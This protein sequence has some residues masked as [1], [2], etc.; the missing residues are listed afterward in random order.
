MAG[1]R[2]AAG[3][4]IA[5]VGLVLAACASSVQIPEPSPGPQ[6][7]HTCRDLHR[8]LPDRLDD[9]RRRPTEPQSQLLAAWGSPPVAL[10]CGVAE[11]SGLRPTS[12]LVTVEG[13][14]WLPEPSAAPTRFTTVGRAV[15]VQVIL[16]S[17]DRPAAAVLVELAGPIAETVPESG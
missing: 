14:D 12:R 7:V 6:A 11:P 5:G 17:E 4:G 10:R 16:G 2:P 9:M 3:L 13:V 15:H 8:M 1:R